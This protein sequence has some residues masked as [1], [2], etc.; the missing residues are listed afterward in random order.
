M[1]ERREPE[2]VELGG[3]ER[4]AAAWVARLDADRSPEAQAQFERWKAQSRS[5]REAADRLSGL[6]SEMDVLGELRA[7]AEPV[8]PLARRPR[9][10]APWLGGKAFGF[11]GMAAAAA[12]AVAVAVLTITPTH[13]GG[14]GLP[15]AQTY[16]TEVGKQRTVN[17]ADGSTVQLNTNSLLQVSFNRGARDVK[18]LRGEAFFEIAPDKQRP[19]T[20]YAGAGAVQAVGTA[21]AVRLENRNVRVTLTRGT[22]RV[23]RPSPN[24]PTTAA[25]R[26]EVVLKAQAGR[27]AEALVTPEDIQREEVTSQ[28]VARELSWR[29]GILV[30][31]GE[32][33]PTVVSNI[34]RYTDVKIEMADPKLRQIKVAGYFDAGDVD[35]MLEA[36]QSGFGVRVERLGPKRVRLTVAGN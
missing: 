17:L 3:P 6:W 26:A 35:P 4:E 27:H 11:A 30:F 13:G 7:L 20:V 25:S 28:V 8:G 32:P 34:S 29:Q 2:V 1:A 14:L 5:N 18:L 31:D 33:L 23:L 19:F 9:R 16:Q 22:V 10:P 36:L 21:F 24:S 15:A 12:A